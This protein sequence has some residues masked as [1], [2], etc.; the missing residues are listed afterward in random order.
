M[1][2]SLETQSPSAALLLLDSSHGEFHLRCDRWPLHLSTTEVRRDGRYDMGRF[3][4]VL[5][6]WK[7]HAHSLAIWADWDRTI[8]I[9]IPRPFD[10]GRIFFLILI[11]RAAH[12]QR[13]SPEEGCDAAS[14]HFGPT[15]KTTD[16]LVIAQHYTRLVYLGY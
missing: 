12:T 8:L 9:F 16:T 7:Q 1:D 14:V 2:W 3:Q 10:P 5:T 11:G 4:R 13:D 15:V 6:V